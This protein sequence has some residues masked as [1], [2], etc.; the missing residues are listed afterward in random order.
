MKPKR[1]IRHRRWPSAV[2]LICA[3]WCR[4]VVSGQAA[5]PDFAA[6]VD[7]SPLHTVA[8]QADGRLRSFESHAAAYMRYVTGP[9]RVDEQSHGFTY[10]DLLFAPE[11]YRTR[12]IIYVKNKLIL[13]Q[14]LDILERG[15]RITPDR[16]KEIEKR[17]L[18]S[19]DLMSV[20]EVEALLVQLES[21]LVRT[22]KPVQQIRT[23]LAVASPRIL[24]AELRLIPRSSP[25]PDKPWTSPYSVAQQ[26]AAAPERMEELAASAGL[27]VDRLTALVDDWIQ[28]SSAW[29]SRDAE[30]VNRILAQLTMD[31]RSILPDGYPEAARLAWESWYFRYDS[32]TWVWLLYLLATI[33]LLIA[34][35]THW[36]A[37]RTIGLFLFLVA[38]AFQTTS[39]GLR[40]YISGRWPNANM[41]EAVTTSAWMGG[42]LA[43]VLEAVFRKSGARNL[44]ALGSSVMSM[45]ALMAAYLLPTSLDSSLNNIMP[46]LHDVWLY[47]HTNVIIW[48]Y[49]VIGLA[50]VTAT[51]FL[52]HRW[53]GLWR[54]R[55]VGRV[56]LLLLPLTL[57]LLHITGW[58][59][60]L[61]VINR[62]QYDLSASFWAGMLTRWFGL[63]EAVGRYAAPYVVIAL[64]GVSLTALLFEWLEAGSRARARLGRSAASAEDASGGWSTAASVLMRPKVALST[65]GAYERSH[66]ELDSRLHGKDALPAVAPGKAGVRSSFSSPSGGPAARVTAADVFDMATMVTMELAFIMLWAGIVMGAIWADHSW[67]RPWGWDPK[68]VFA[69]NTFII[70]LVL[71]HV[72]MKVRDKGFWTAVLAVLGFETMMFNWIVINFIVTGLHS[73]A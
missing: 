37:A 28:L 72:R 13:I 57:T 32:M 56:R 20:P 44:F 1:G 67:G 14:V 33:P 18:I 29:R 60:L 11:T 9:R 46:A 42:V 68:E 19:P 25:E 47:I 61:A 38:F 40:W 12:D 45:A 30:A 53:L 73:Y 71:V 35:I 64:F 21:D 65:A 50:A 39:V 34:V 51:L 58:Q 54:S 66:D 69:L 10:L 27:R 6:R 15:G 16:R 31:C 2:A 8:V 7:L 55:E 49:A 5:A 52:A 26:R 4:D 22:A 36:P 62:E 3:T 41:F 63:S 24:G 59:V 43:L 17:R 23:A 48:S 70:F